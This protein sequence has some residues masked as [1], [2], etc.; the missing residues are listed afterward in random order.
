MNYDELK[1]RMIDSG[2]TTAEMLAYISFINSIIFLREDKQIN[3]TTFADLLD[4][5]IDLLDSI[6]NV[7]CIPD[8]TLLFKMLNVLNSQ[9]KIEEKK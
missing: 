3:Q 5:D 1:Q 2:Q 7:Q 8:I 9:A 6:E 4:I